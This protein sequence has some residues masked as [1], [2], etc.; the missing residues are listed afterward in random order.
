MNAESLRLDVEAAEWL[1]QK[2]NRRQ[3][4]LNFV[5]L[6]YL[7]GTQQS[8]SDKQTGILPAGVSPL[9]VVGSSSPKII[10]FIEIIVV[11][12][13]FFLQKRALLNRFCLQKDTTNIIIINIVSGAWMSADSDDD[14]RTAEIPAAPVQ[15]YLCPSL[16]S[17]LHSQVCLPVGIR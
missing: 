1:I 9:P 16:P 6:S 2:L 17:S 4:T 8:T 3:W 5:L 10:Q 11:F 12:G 13:D 15:S 7:A 14:R